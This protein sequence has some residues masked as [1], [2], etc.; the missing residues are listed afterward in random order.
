MKKQCGFAFL[1]WLVVLC[2]LVFVLV[3]VAK[4]I[5]SYIEFQ[6]IKGAVDE[7]A[8]STP[9]KMSELDVHQLRRRLDSLLQINRFS[10]VGPENFSVVKMA[11]RGNASALQVDY[12]VR[13]NWFANIDLMLKFSHQ[14]E[15]KG[16]EP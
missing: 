10:N 4:M 11:D 15:L 1:N 5:P 9:R 2:L 7:M 13:K 16:T 6:S 14:A 12:E 3:T 8:A